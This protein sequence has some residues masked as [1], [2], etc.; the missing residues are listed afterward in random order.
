M[1]DRAEEEASGDKA[2]SIALEKTKITETEQNNPSTVKR[3]LGAEEQA[4]LEQ[5]KKIAN[6]QYELRCI[7]EKNLRITRKALL[8][9]ESRQYSEDAAKSEKELLLEAQLRSQI[10]STARAENKLLREADKIGAVESRLT[11]AKQRVVEANAEVRSN[12]DA[13]ARAI[14][15]ARKS[16]NFA[17]R[18]MEARGRAERQLESTRIQLSIQS[19]TTSKIL[20]ALEREKEKNRGL[21]NRLE[22]LEEHQEAKGLRKVETNTTSKPWLSRVTT[23]A[24]KD[25]PRLVRKIAEKG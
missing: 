13:R 14:L 17:K 15:T 3:A 22:A 23:A 9:L 16:V 19:D 8:K 5:A 12:I 4:F 2:N 18:S 10:Q 21:L 25:K 1:H 6:Q 7:S 24:K 20:K 11:E